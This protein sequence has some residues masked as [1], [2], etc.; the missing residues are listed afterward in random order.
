[1]DSDKPVELELEL[2]VTVAQ[3]D[4]PRSRASDE[5]VI[6]RDRDS[7]Q[8][9]FLGEGDRYVVIRT[10][11]AADRAT[12]RVGESEWAGSLPGGRS[13][14]VEIGVCELWQ[15]VLGEEEVGEMDAEDAA[16]LRALGYLE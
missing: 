14:A 4:R 8:L 11:E 15:T 12:V 3:L 2:P 10:L 13:E 9:R 16:G 1:M 5:P 7:V 6:A